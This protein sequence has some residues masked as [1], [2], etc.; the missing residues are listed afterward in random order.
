MQC[1][2]YPRPALQL[3]KCSWRGA[4]RGC[5]DQFDKTRGPAELMCAYTPPCEAFYSPPNGFDSPFTHRKWA[6]KVEKMNALHTFS[7]E[8]ATRKVVQRPTCLQESSKNHLKNEI[9]LLRILTKNSAKGGCKLSIANFI[10]VAIIS[11][12]RYL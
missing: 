12:N 10:K 9:L 11:N 8:R 2:F 3:A 1:I 4:Y 6:G 5:L 7:R